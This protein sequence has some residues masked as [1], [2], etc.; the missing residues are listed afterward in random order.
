MIRHDKRIVAI[1][2]P[3]IVM[4]LGVLLHQIRQ[5]ICILACPTWT[6]IIYPT[7]SSSTLPLARQL[8]HFHPH[9]PSRKKLAS[10]ECSSQY[11][12]ACSIHFLMLSHDSTDCISNPLKSLYTHRFPPPSQARARTPPP[13]SFGPAALTFRPLNS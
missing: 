5:I 13:D 6:L 3:N 11:S 1:C 10:F 9:Q 12:N 2:V 4:I 8:G 7:P